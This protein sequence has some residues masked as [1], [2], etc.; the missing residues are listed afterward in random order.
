MQI[1]F[2]YIVVLTFSCADVD[3]GFVGVQII[4]LSFLFSVFEW[5]HYVFPLPLI[6]LFLSFRVVPLSY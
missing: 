4:C 3:K 1:A 2:T 5:V 6:T